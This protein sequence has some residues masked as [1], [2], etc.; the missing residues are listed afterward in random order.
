MRYRFSDVFQESPNGSIAPKMQVQIGGVTMSPGVSFSQGV[1]FSGVD[2]TKSRGKDIEGDLVN[3]I[4]VI[5]GF[6]N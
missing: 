4:L 5:K 6:Y 2:I 3:G 1:S